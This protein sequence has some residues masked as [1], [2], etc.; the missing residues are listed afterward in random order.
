MFFSLPEKPS[1]KM[2]AVVD[3]WHSSRTVYLFLSIFAQLEASA[4]KDEMISCV[5]AKTGLENKLVL[6]MVYPESQLRKSTLSRQ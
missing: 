3:Y 4:D 5:G 6:R 1:K 2:A